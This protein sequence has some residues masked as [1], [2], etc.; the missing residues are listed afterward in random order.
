MEKDTGG[1]V[2]PPAGSEG[3]AWEPDWNSTTGAW[4]MV[5]GKY[6]KRKE[7]VP[8]WFRVLERFGL[9]T[10]LALACMAIIGK[11]IDNDRTDRQTGAKVMAEAMKEQTQVMTTALKDVS[12]KV[13]ENTKADGEW[14][15][16]QR[17]ESRAR[18]NSTLK[19]GK[20]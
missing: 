4:Y 17:G 7:D 13:E 10:L 19:G 20:K 9:P 16:E 8:L 15:A 12:T 11:M 2:L 3:R 1:R 6:G 18:L 14:R 5:K